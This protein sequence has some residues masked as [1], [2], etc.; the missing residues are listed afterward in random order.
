V[1]HLQGIIGQVAGAILAATASKAGPDGAGG[2]KLVF[3]KAPLYDD[4]LNL[5]RCLKGSLS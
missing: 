4:N 3:L 5:T 1:D 2:T